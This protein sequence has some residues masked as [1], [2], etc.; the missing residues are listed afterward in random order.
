MTRLTLPVINLATLWQPDSLRALDCACRNWGAFQLVGHPITPLLQSRLQGAMRG[1]FHQPRSSK[2]LIERSA[3]NPWGYYDQ[4]LTR[5]AQ[6]WKEVFDYGPA[7]GD[8]LTP[9]WP[10]G[11]DDFR[12]AVLSYYHLCEKI[13]FDLLAAI[14]ANLGGGTEHVQNCFRPQHTSFVRLNYY[15]K[16]AQPAQPTG[17]FAATDGFLGVNPHTDAGALTLLLQDEQAG[18]EIY[19]DERWHEIAGGTLVVNI[20]DI[21]QVWS[22][23]RY[24]APL[25]R[26]RANTEAERFSVPF[27]FNP[28]YDTQYAPLRATVDQRHPPR[29]RHIEWGEFRRQRTDGDY[30]NHGEEIQIS[31]FR[32]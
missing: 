22:N 28:S 32:V 2:L 11:V 17:N 25:H 3:N 20:G 7:D 30:A 4:E 16:C 23:D 15:P 6:D 1:F 29:Y 24:Q 8:A 5:Q 26:V 13:A 27:F 18:L 9:Q 10:E 21:L 19:R 14:T 12:V 31:Q